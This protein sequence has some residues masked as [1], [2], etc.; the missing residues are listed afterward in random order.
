MASEKDLAALGIEPAP[1]DQFPELPK[2]VQW[3]Y[4]WIDLIREFTRNLIG[5]G[6][7]WGV[8][9][10]LYKFVQMAQNKEN[11]MLLVIGYLGGFLTG[12][13]TWY[14]GG[15]MRSAM[16]QFTQKKGA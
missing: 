1:L 4:P 3:V 14:F 15:A 16:A 2:D 6:S 11:I 7:V 12:V 13:A 10:M 5:M 8:L 9:Y